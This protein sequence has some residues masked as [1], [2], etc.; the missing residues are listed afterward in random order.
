MIAKLRK[1]PTGN[2]TQKWRMAL[3]IDLS[4][5]GTGDLEV[6]SNT[7]DFHRTEFWTDAQVISKVRVSSGGR[8]QTHT[9]P[10]TIFAD[11]LHAGDCHLLQFS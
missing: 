5:R 9:T 8:S 10:I 2:D 6:R 7:A 1:L 4:W 11:F 3:C